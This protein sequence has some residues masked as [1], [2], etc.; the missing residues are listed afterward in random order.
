MR[1]TEPRC[2][3]DAVLTTSGHMTSIDIVLTS[4]LRPYV[5]STSI[6]RHSDV[7]C[8]LGGHKATV[9]IYEYF[10]HEQGTIHITQQAHDVKTT[11]LQ[12]HHSA[13]SQYDDILM[14]YA[15][16]VVLNCIFI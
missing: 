9:G 13:S 14:S 1:L 7:M 15:C 4:I 12:R 3:N 5:V 2:R 10:T 6:R 8:Q 11:S 16:W